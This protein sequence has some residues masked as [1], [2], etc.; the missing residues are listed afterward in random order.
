[1]I[2]VTI[3]NWH[4]ARLN[5]LFSG[6]WGKRKRLKD[7]DRD[8]IGVY[9]HGQPEATKKRRVSLIIT[10]GPRQRGGDPDS[11]WKS[12]LDSLVHANMLINDSPNW[13]ELGQVQYTRDNLRST[14]I[15]LEDL[16]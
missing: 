13:V 5:Q 10:L 15:L 7:A 6:H 11:Y 2:A 8:M 1:M 4:P 16:A 14:T 12:V 3:P 9:C